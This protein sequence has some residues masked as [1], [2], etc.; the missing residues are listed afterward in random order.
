MRGFPKYEF[1]RLLYDS[2]VDC[3]SKSLLPEANWGAS[4][5]DFLLSSYIASSSV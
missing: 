4:V 2:T 3:K 5:A 1:E